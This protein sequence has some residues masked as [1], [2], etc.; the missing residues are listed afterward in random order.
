MR[1][2]RK[3]VLGE[4]PHKKVKKWPVIMKSDKK[5]RFSSGGGMIYCTTVSTGPPGNVLEIGKEKT[6]HPVGEG[7]CHGR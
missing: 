4:K 7:M 3:D 2:G 5:Y 6:A 1:N